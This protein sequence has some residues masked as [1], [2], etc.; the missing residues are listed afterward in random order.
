MKLQKQAILF[1]MDGTLVGLKPSGRLAT[2]RGALDHFGITDIE[3]EDADRFWFTAERYKMLENWSIPAEKFWQILDSEELLYLQL[4]HTVSFRDTGV[5]RHLSRQR[6]G[7]GIVSNSAHI[8]LQ[9][10]LK[11][12]NRHLN[13]GCFNQIVS[14]SEDAPRPKP[15]PSGILL[16]LERMGIAPHEALLVGDSMDDV[17]A[18]YAAGVEVAIIDRGEPIKFDS[19]YP[20]YRLN[21]LWKLRS[22]IVPQAVRFSYAS[23]RVTSVAA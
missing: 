12:L 7:L 20:F 18:G 13:P 9:S 11:L 23:D 21:S 3:Q 5:I 14:C 10:K 17:R 19:A 8:S 15:C 16:G 2:L 1:D 4:Q 6:I 22:W